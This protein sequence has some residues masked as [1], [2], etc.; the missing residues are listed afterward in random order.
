MADDIIGSLI[1][2]RPLADAYAANV[3]SLGGA[4]DSYEEKGER[5]IISTDMGNVSHLV[6]SIHPFYSVGSRVFNH[7][8]EFTAIAGIL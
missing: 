2:N 8:Q 1:H 3:I 6:P 7:T 5:L 4:V